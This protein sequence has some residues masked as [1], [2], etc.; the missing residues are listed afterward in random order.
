[1]LECKCHLSLC[2][3]PDRILWLK[4]AG[5]RL[6]ALP[7]CFLM[8]CLSRNNAWHQTQPGGVR[9]NR[10]SCR[11][12]VKTTA[13]VN[14]LKLESE[15]SHV[16]TLIHHN[17]LWGLRNYHW[18]KWLLCET[19]ELVADVGEKIYICSNCDLVLFLWT[20]LILFKYLAF[21]KVSVTSLNTLVISP[22]FAQKQNKI[23]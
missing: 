8:D 22:L 19:Q 7:V 23:N 6:S 14:K 3:L 4:R 11:V 15:L 16:T 1:M 9:V 10:C 18:Q 12:C 20:H 21:L 2:F 17:Y 13:I 5:P